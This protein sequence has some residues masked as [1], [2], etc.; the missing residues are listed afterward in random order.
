MLDCILQCSLCAHFWANPGCQQEN[1]D[2]LRRN[3]ACALGDDRIVQWVL[4][5]REVIKESNFR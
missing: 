5:I 4:A 2:V 3:G 1:L